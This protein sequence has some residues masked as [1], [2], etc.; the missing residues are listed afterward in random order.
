[1]FDALCAECQYGEPKASRSNMQQISTEISERFKM[2]FWI[3]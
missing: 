3:K 1:M 2:L